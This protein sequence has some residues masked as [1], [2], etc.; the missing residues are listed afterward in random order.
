ME[1]PSAKAPSSARSK[2]ADKG[3]LT[4]TRQSNEPLTCDGYTA[5]DPTSFQFYLGNSTLG[6]VLY[7]VTYTVNSTARGPA[8]ACLG[9]RFRF[10][11]SSGADARSVTLPNGLS[12]FVGLLPRC[13]KDQL[14]ELVACLVSR[15][16]AGSNTVLTAQVPAI[17]GDPWMRS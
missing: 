16:P 13:R 12:G 1:L 5:S 8:Q 6:N 4:W 2:P 17:G 11:T 15:K 14:G 9:A 10:T 3:M 7:S